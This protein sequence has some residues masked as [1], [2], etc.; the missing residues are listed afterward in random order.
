MQ[1]RSLQ[2]IYPRDSDGGDGQ[3]HWPKL[4]ADSQSDLLSANGGVNRL[5]QSGVG[6]D[7]IRLVVV[8]RTG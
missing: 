1:S 3:V 4:V 5:T 6:E 8:S 2:Y 7:E